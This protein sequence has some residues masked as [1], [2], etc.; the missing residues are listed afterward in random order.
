[1]KTK[2]LTTWELRELCKQIK[3]EEIT[4]HSDN[5][6][7]EF[8]ELGIKFDLRFSDIDFCL[9]PDIIYLMNGK[10]C[11][12]I[13]KIKSIRERKT[14]FLGRC[15]DITCT[16]FIEENKETTHTLLIG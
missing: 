16:G 3:P 13:N 15:F 12:M 1:M 5:G 2:T 14:V 9:N 6:S 11:L 7:F 10:S 4:Y 8:S